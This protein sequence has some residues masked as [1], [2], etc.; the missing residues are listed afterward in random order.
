MSFH[1][2]RP[3]DFEGHN[4]EVRRVWRAYHAGR[5]HRVPV[6]ICG[7]IR[8]Y[9]NNPELN[10]SGFDF[11]DFFTDPRAQVEC[12]LAWQKYARWNIVCDREMGPPQGGWPL[13]VDLQNSYEAG[14]FGCPLRCFGLDVPDTEEILKERK[15]RLFDL[16]PPDPLR[17]G[18]LGRAMEFFDYMHQAGPR[19]E[20]EGLPVK[21]PATIPGE[22]TDGPFTVACKLR[23]AAEVCLDLYEDPEYFHAL[24]DFVT[25]Q[26][27]RRM[28]AIR[29][30][31]WSL[32]PESPDRGQFRRPGWY[33]ADDS[34]ALLSVGQYRE[35]VL[36]YHRRLVAEFSDG[37]GVS[38]HLCGDATR[39]FPTLKAELGVRTFDTGF[40][41][42]FAWLRRELGPE[43]RINGGPSIML[44]KDGP[45]AAIA[46]EVRRI[47]GSGI[48]DGGRFVLI[49]ANN[50]A[51]CTPIEHVEA[52]SEAGKR[53]GT[54]PEA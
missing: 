26:T 44:V 33:F 1:R 18:L 10:R 47:C 23:G 15:E 37:T 36:P 13:A 48:M 52:L 41:V 21:P 17:G 9:F 25:A 38:M 35:F 3:I 43:V 29:E 19:M 16:E 51:P 40:P 20:F 53:F 31:R 2:S 4:E 22:G 49:A 7:S 11:E 28:K 42:D 32:R 46:G 34:I 12:Q 6:E 14:W 50:L 8:N 30:W 27:I 45:S 5:P 54:Y 24:M 39:H